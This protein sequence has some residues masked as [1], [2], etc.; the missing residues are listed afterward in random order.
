MIVDCCIAINYHIAVNNL[1]KQNSDIDKKYNA[2]KKKIKKRNDRQII[3]NYN[4]RNHCHRR[5]INHFIL[6]VIYH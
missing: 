5:L 6:N 3:E 4:H 1:N 2:N